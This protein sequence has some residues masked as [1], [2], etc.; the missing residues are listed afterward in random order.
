MFVATVGLPDAQVVAIFNIFVTYG[1]A[2]L[3]DAGVYDMLYYELLR[4]R[5]VF[6]AMHEQGAHNCMHHCHVRSHCV[7]VFPTCP[8]ANRAAKTRGDDRSA[9]ARLLGGLVNIRVSVL[10]SDPAWCPLSSPARAHGR[11]RN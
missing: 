4:E 8:P 3:P 9:A 7:P 5:D 11:C 10:P 1:D 2:F 6:E